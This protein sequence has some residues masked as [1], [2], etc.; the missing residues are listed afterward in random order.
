MKLGLPTIPNR[1]RVILKRRSEGPPRFP[2]RRTPTVL[3]IEAVECGAASL[4]MILGYYGRWV[5]L[6]ELRHECG[7]SR[8]GA[9]AANIV[10]AARKFGMEA[11]GVR[12]DLDEAFALRRPFIAFWNF[13]HYVVVEGATRRKVYLNDPAAGP[14]T[15]TMAEF[16]GSFTGVV[17]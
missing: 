16:R 3:Q 8:D 14:R 7:V 4:A 11:R 6:E 17:L 2:R 5:A 12:A 15:V 9:K 10:K 1:L 13:N